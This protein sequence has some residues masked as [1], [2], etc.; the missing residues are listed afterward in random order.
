MISHV[1][2][3]RQIYRRYA[4]GYGLGT[5]I[6]G[7]RALPPSERQ[8]AELEMNSSPRVYLPAGAAGANYKNMTNGKIDPTCS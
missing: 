7:F 5:T 3:D 2:I 8:T 6:A 1:N 4:I